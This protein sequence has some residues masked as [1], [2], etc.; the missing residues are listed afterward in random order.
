MLKI[1]KS[2][3]SLEAGLYRIP[4]QSL[5]TAQDTDEVSQEEELALSEPQQE[6]ADDAKAEAEQILEAAKQEAQAI[7]DQ[8]E[9]TAVELKTEA[10]E[11][12]SAEGQVQKEQLVVDAQKLVV[13]AQYLREEMLR[14][15]EPQVVELSLQIAEAILKTSVS[16]NVDVIKEVVAEAIS[17]LAGEDSIIVQVNPADIG[18]CRSYKETLVDLLADE[19]AIKFVPAPE[20]AR[21]N[22][23]VQGEYALVEANIQDRFSLLQQAMLKEINHA[24]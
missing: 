12:A 14:L 4:L 20:V 16:V 17:L 7:L 24:T 1:I 19:A 2:G 15:V 10:L 11:Q 3:S 9:A 18:I 8:A 5:V 22:C 6:Q 23:I 13:E 21:G